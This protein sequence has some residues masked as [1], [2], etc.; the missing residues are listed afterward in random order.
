M[1]KSSYTKNGV[2][3]LKIIFLATG[4]GGPSYPSI[5]QSKI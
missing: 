4:M 5:G 1:L 2:D 3:L